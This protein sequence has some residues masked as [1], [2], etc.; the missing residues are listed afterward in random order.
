MDGK[1]VWLHKQQTFDD[2]MVN[3]QLA[4]KIE[5]QRKDSSFFVLISYEFSYSE[6]MEWS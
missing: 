5:E 6:L 1:S 3:I 4:M 2:Q